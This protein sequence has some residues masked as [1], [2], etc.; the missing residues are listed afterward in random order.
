MDDV[1]W[2]EVVRYLDDLYDASEGLE[3]M[4][5]GRKFTLDG[6]LVGSVGEVVA[7]YIFDLDLFT[8]STLGHDAKSRDGR[9]VEVKLTQRTSVGIRHKPEHL[10]A[11]HRAK[12][13]PVRVVYNGPGAF[14]WENAGRMQSNGQRSISLSQLESLDREVPHEL[15][16]QTVRKPPI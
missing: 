5:L 16:L 10:I 12:G 7:A 4:F 1:N 2:D 6:H 9:N 11:L 3:Q 15:R 8:A 14:A 13:G